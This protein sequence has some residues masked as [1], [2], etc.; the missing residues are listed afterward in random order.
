M[1]IAAPSLN[2]L[3]VLQTH[4]NFRIFWLG[5]TTSLIGTWM[6]STAQ[7]WLAL[8]LSNSAFVVGLVV[9]AGA[10]PILLLSLYGGVIADR[11]DKLRLVTVCQAL[12]L[13]NATM[14]WWFVWSGRITVGWLL[15]FALV[16]GT[17]NAFEIPTRQSFIIELVGRDDLPDAIALNSGGFN[18]A[19][20]IGPSLAGIVINELGIAAAYAVNA[21]S[22][23]AVLT[24]LF[25]IRL[26]P[27]AV[28]AVTTS[29]LE[30]LAEGV[31]Y[32]RRSRAVS[33]LM[34]MVAV[35]SIFGMP[36]LALMPV[37]ARDVLGSGASGYGL[38]LTCVGIGGFSG[39]LALATLGRRIRR[40]RLLEL[41]AYAFAILLVVFSFTRSLA[42]SAAL[43][44]G[45]GFSMI[46]SNA[47]AN[48]L[49]QTM[50]PDE[51]RGRVMAAYAWLFVGVGPVLGP[52]IAGALADQIG[53][54]PT[55]ALSAAVPLLYAAWA[56]G[57][58]PELRAL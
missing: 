16:A 50:V 26:P 41:A 54:A 8:Q 39:A 42:L 17:V 28:P 13:L 51:L 19:R 31:R 20:V 47:L 24:S 49:L 35:Y 33:L 1:A 14:L 58:R 52:F 27:R 6:Q 7:A 29:P 22:Y 38:L 55:I 9:T 56:F 32:M 57:R 53:A 3:R 15:A 45:V 5:Q 4:R 48:A 23:F 21:V 36:Y 12:L 43:L 30:G 40:G 37:F 25:S 34:G 18:L 2:P 10:L 46:L 11:T 44:L